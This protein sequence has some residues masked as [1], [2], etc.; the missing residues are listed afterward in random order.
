SAKIDHRSDLYSLG[1]L[2]YQLVCGKVPFE[3]DSLAEIALAHIRTPLISPKQFVP[4]LPE[5]L[6]TVIS[7]LLKKNPKDR[8]NSS[9]EVSKI[10]DTFLKDG[11][12]ENLETFGDFLLTPGFV[13]RRKEF[14]VLNKIFSETTN[15]LKTILI[16]GEQGV[17]K[18]K[19]W[20]EFRLGLPQNTTLV[21]ETKCRQ[22][23]NTFESLQIILTKALEQIENLSSKEQAEKIGRFGRDLS[24]ILP[25]LESKLFYKHLPELQTL[26]GSDSELR[27]FEAYTTFLQNIHKENQTLVFFFDDLQ[28]LNEQSL[29]FLGYLSRSLSG[30]SVLL[31]GTIRA[32]ETE[33]IKSEIEDSEIL[34]LDNFNLEEVREFLTKMFGKTDPVN[35]RFCEEI[36]KRT[37]GNVLFVQELLYHLLETKK[38]NKKEGDWD[39]GEE[40][41]SELKLPKSIQS[42]VGERL[43]FLPRD[44]VKLLELGSLLGKYFNS[45]I[46]SGIVSQDESKIDS[47]LTSSTLEGIL[48]KAE[49]D[50]FEFVNDSFRESLSNSIKPTIKKSLH[51]KIATYL[52][53]NFDELEVLE[54]LANHY[55]EANA[56]KKALVFCLKLGDKA[57]ENKVFQS[58]SKH[59]QKV[60]NLIDDLKQAKSNFE[61]YKKYAQTLAS[62]NEVDK[63]VEFYKKAS[64]LIRNDDEKK[65]EIL[66]GLGRVKI[67]AA[68]MDEAESH[69][70][71]SLEIC[72]KNNFFNQKVDALSDLGEIE[73]QKGNFDKTAEY[74]NQII[75]ISEKEDLKKLVGTSYALLGNVAGLKGYFEES[76]ELHKKDLEVQNLYGSKVRI[77]WAKASLANCYTRFYEFENSKPI[78]EECLILSKEIGFPKGISFAFGSLGTGFYSNGE[79]EKA[80]EYLKN[81]AEISLKVKDKNGYTSARIQTAITYHKLGEFEKSEELFLEQLKVTKESGKEDLTLSILLSG[82]IDMLTDAKKYEFLLEIAEEAI[83]LLTRMKSY[84][85]LLNVYFYKANAL[86]ELGKF[87]LSE[88]TFEEASKYFDQ[89]INIV[90]AKLR[91]KIL[92]LKLDFELH[93]KEKAINDLIEMRTDDSITKNL[94]QWA[95]DFELCLLYS[96]NNE[97]LF[98]DKKLDFSKLKNQTLNILRKKY[99]MKPEFF[100]KN[101]LEVLQSLQFRST[102]IYPELINSLINWMNPETVFEELLKFLQKETNANSCQIILQNKN[103]FETCAVSQNLK[104]DEIEFSKSVLQKAIDSEMPTLLKNVLEIP[105]L[106]ENQSVIGKI[107]LSV[108]AVPLKVENKIIG[109]LYLD[110]TK[111][112]KGFF[113]NIDLEKVNTIANLLSPVLQKQNEAVKRKI[114]SEIQNLGIFIGRSKKMEEVYSEIENASKVNFTVY[115]HGETGTGKE[116]VAKSL[117]KLSS[118]RK[119]PFVAVNCSAI[120]KDLAESE[121]F[122]HEKGAFSGATATKEGKFELANNGTLFLDEVAELSLEVQSKLLRVLQEKEIWRVGGKGSRKIDVRIVVATHKNLSEEV[123]KGN[124]REDLF[125]RL[126]VLKIEIP[127]LRDRKEDIPLLAYHFLEKYENEIDKKVYGFSKDALDILSQNEFKGNVRELE[128]VI[129]KALVKFEGNREL[130]ANDFSFGKKLK[131]QIDISGISLDSLIKSILPFLEGKNFDEKLSTL[132][133]EILEET[134]FKNKGNKRKTSRDLNISRNRLERLV[135]KYNL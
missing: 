108:I 130:R 119:N 1:V 132:E 74:A 38:L 91:L 92:K 60:I 20:K 122:G 34:S 102:E 131:P 97:T 78:L 101:K 30:S 56:K 65:V 104:S 113:S 52:E 66:I 129:L 103:R 100:N 77:F 116:L 89:K 69:L 94:F 57:F 11:K 135:S 134:L 61:I 120:P 45:E 37:G 3:G 96:K 110:R 48:E 49:S 121:L 22:N 55:F 10:L 115:I 41:F 40:S 39:L 53:K 54:E 118:R 64:E 125:H 18:T 79:F 23:S 117:H 83:P 19:L 9:Q 72:E 71:K 43:N 107:F 26:E 76:I 86:F 67:S 50:V 35:T 68:K 8:F 128:N 112:E 81:A 29:K 51:K 2:F 47:K 98:L 124:F 59:Y 133:K 99:E 15:K 13:G 6:N 31:I 21:F 5:V 90:N 63:S 82:F 7:K 73:F 44:L 85:Y 4:D 42:V 75:E 27:L 127:P 62:T 16:S 105:E 106:K 32:G 70:I 25:Q 93:N 17:G 28:W 33:K 87:N 114:D 123:E 46:V 24:K 14:I 126:D 36:L 58:A 12:V 109:A 111:V 80:V 88:S 84:F 95:V